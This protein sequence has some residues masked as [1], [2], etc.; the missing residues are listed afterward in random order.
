LVALVVLFLTPLH[1]DL[2]VPLDLVLAVSIEV[3]VVVVRP[4][5]LQEP[6]LGLLLDL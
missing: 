4:L 1:R 2:V 5:F 3:F 6:S